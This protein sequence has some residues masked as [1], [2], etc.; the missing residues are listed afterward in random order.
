[1]RIQDDIKSKYSDFKDLL[2]SHNVKYLY[3][4]GSSVTDSFQE[5]DSDID[6]MIIGDISGRK[7]SSAMIQAGNELNKEVNF[8]I[9]SP[10]EFSRRLKSNDHFINSIYQ[11][12]K[13]FIIGD[14]DELE[15]LGEK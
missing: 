13:L 5:P 6:L 9:I 7:I 14:P 4:F 12:S 11:E 3:A 2:I 1:M 8:N 10:D 15:R